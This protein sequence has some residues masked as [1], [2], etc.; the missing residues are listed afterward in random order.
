[1]ACHALLVQIGVLGATGPA[2]RGIAARLASLGYEVLAGSRALERSESAVLA[3]QEKWG[4]KVKTLFPV[5]NDS[6]ANCEMV[7]VATNWEA[8]V[9]T[10][11]LYSSALAGRTVIA[12]ANGLEKVG[13]EFRPVIPPEGSLSAAIQAAAPEAKVVAAFQ[14]IPA[15]TFA[16]LDK[17]M[18][19]DVV[20]CGDDD[21]AR[22]VVLDLVAS[23][24]DLRGF[25]AGSLVNAVGIETFAADLLSIN[26]RHKGKGTLRFLGLK[27][28]LPEANR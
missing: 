3:L 23:M 2:G 15:S 6:A 24:P 7:I 22:N 27:G 19:G 11:I 9:D 5:D 28:Y 20:V 12:M 8:A 26:L 13:Q 25:D 4:N 1:M 10:T 21:D 14:H 16:A 17:K 18:E